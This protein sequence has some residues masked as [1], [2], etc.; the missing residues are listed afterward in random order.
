MYIIFFKIINIFYIILYTYI[1]Y[2]CV[3]FFKLNWQSAK[4]WLRRLWRKY[5]QVLDTKVDMCQ[6]VPVGAHLRQCNV[7]IWQDFVGAQQLM[8]D[9]FLVHPF[10]IKNQTVQ[11]QVRSFDASIVG[12]KYYRVLIIAML[13]L[14][15]WILLCT[16]AYQIVWVNCDF[17]HLSMYQ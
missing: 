16:T 13:H 3:T 4:P 5:R 2:Y 6:N 15:G 17:C 14:H 11:Q 7:T 8:E 1:H 9:R 10:D 12:W